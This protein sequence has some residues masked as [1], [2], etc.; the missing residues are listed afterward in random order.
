MHDQGHLPQLLSVSDTNRDGAAKGLCPKGLI[1]FS[2]SLFSKEHNELTKM[3]RN[4]QVSG[5]RIP[6]T[7]VH[8]MLIALTT[9]QHDG[10]HS[11]D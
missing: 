10:V 5:K 7:I 9:A 8:R 1:L 4:A 6:L 3:L 2:D 11:Q